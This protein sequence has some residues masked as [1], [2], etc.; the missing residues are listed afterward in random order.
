MQSFTCSEYQKTNVKSELS[1]STGK[2]PGIELKLFMNPD[3]KL[4]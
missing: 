1:S 4:T 2:L 3:K